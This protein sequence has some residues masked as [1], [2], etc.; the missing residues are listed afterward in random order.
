MLFFAALFFTS[1]EDDTDP[2]VVRPALSILSGT[3]FTVAPEEVVEVSISAVQGDNPMNG[4]YLY[5]DGSLVSSDR[6]SIVTENGDVL[7]G[8]NP[9]LITG[10]ATATLDWTVQITAQST[11]ATSATYTIEIADNLG[12]T[13]S[14]SVTIN[15]V[16]TAPTLTAAPP[17]TFEIPS[18]TLYAFNLTG[19]VGT[20]NLSSIEVQEN[21]VTIDAAR[22]GW[23]G[24][25]SID[26]NPFTLTDSD[27]SGF[28]MARLDID[29][30]TELGTYNYLFILND[31][32]GLSDSV[33]YEVTIVAAGTPVDLR[34]DEVL[35]QSGQED[36]GLDLDT[37]EN[38][39]SKNPLSPDAEIIDNG[40]NTDLPVPSNWIQTISP[41][42]G[43]TM[44]YVVAGANGIP[45]GFT[46]E[47]VE[48]K[49]DIP[50][51]YE[52]NTG[53]VIDE[54]STTDV[55]TVGDM[56]I[57]TNNGNYWLLV[58]KEVIVTSN[59]NDDKYIFDVKY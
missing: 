12:N 15:T 49:E 14:S 34:E 51:L 46:F 2:S 9:L 37:G 41:V 10:D 55:V 43:T 27:T 56:F 22:L 29:L 58:V 28:T 33:N 3:D 40:I 59:D 57:V 44:K 20:G 21:G 18:G 17:T 6:F 38:V 39:P 52:N 5:Q 16:G 50:G 31:E 48:V 30:A 4:V 26:G 24:P 36:G 32:Y 25:S 47:S 45:E 1:C 8:A 13:T 23:N 19:V 53:T 7:N 11:A 54:N 35:N 42:N